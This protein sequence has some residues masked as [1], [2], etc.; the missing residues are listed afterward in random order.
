MSLSTK[1]LIWV[2]A[3]LL[4]CAL[5]FIIFKQVEN[6]KRQDA[7]EQNMV[8]QKQLLDGI[9]R[10]QSTWATREDVEK[11]ARENGLNLKTIQDDLDKLHAEVSAVN[12][13]VSHSNGQTG[14]HIPT[15]PGPVVNPN[16]VDPENPDPYGYQKQQQT[17][18]LNEDFSSV[19]VPIGSVGFSAW[20]KE[21]W[22]IDIKGR[23]YK[24]ATVV[25][26]DENQRSYFYNKFT[27]VVDNKDY[28]VPI[29]SAITEQ[30]YPTAKM[31]WFNP[32]LYLTTGGAINFTQAPLQGS[33]NIGATVGIMSYGQYKTA[34][35]ISILQIGVGYETGTQRPAAILNPINF[36]IGGIFPKGL[37]NSTYVG[38]S[39][40]LDT[41]GN[42]FGGANLSVGL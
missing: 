31:S 40:Q 35:T 22:N 11:F 8:A 23:Q 20:Q 14:N 6:A 29:T 36:N 41:G 12:V 5:G 9:V 3:V 26:T 4:L 38:P 16:P 37:I 24:L 17:L 18:A 32:R 39:L 15:V 42:V 34:P 2:G 13:A 10:S 19:K 28:V 1:I 21:P 27:V 7:I 33:A 25:G 30:V